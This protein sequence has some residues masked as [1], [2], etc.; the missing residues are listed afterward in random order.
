MDFI[1]KRRFSFLNND[2]DRMLKKCIALNNLQEGRRIHAY[3]IKTGLSICVFLANR[4]VETYAKC[5]NLLDARNMFDQMPMRNIFSWNTIIA[6]YFKRGIIDHARQLFEKMPERDGVSW[7]TMIAGYDR[8]GYFHEALN[9]YWEMMAEGIAPSPI[10]FAT[11]LSSCAKLP[12]TKQ[13]KQVHA[14]AIGAKCESDVFVGVSLVDMYAKGGFIED[15]RQVFDRMPGRNV[16]SWN[17]MMTGY[18]ENGCG[19]E[20][21]RLFY[22]MQQVGM[23]PDHVTIIT[24]LSSCSKCGKVKDARKVFDQTPQRNASSWNAM[25]AGYVQNGHGEQAVQLFSQMLREDVRSDETTFA[26]VVTACASLAALQQGKQVHGL[27]FRSGFESSVFVGSALV[28]LYSKCGSTEDAQQVFEDMPERN[29][30]SWNAMITGYA[31]NGMGIVAI[32]LFEEMLQA[33]IVPNHVTYVSVLSACSHAGLMDEGLRYFNF[34]SEKHHIV[35]SASHY[36]C[37]IDLLGRAGRLHEAEKL[38]NNAMWVQL[39]QTLQCGLHC[40]VPVGFMGIWSWE[41]VPVSAYL[42]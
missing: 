29:L 31:Q 27:V 3:L 28:D 8:L 7:N 35:P 16:V 42:K 21:L 9:C 10:T 11:V 37:M 33:G 39:N 30:V 20:A 4:L 1:H 5:D 14:R 12:A 25:I 24:V 34:M 23:K 18:G 17:A 36:T 41:N 26:S 6:G 32:Q 22:E 13:G 2:C 38:V 40:L 15:A 19:E